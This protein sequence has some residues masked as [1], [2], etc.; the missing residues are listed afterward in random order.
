[1]LDHFVTLPHVRP[2]FHVSMGSLLIFPREAGAPEAYAP[3]IFVGL[4]RSRAE[5]WLFGERCNSITETA[6]ADALAFGILVP[7]KRGMKGYG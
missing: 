6:F 4:D 7:A 5:V 3:V 1:M 2:A